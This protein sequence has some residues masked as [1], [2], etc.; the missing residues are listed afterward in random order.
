MKLDPGTPLEW[1]VA[2][3]IDE[4]AVVP[5]QPVAAFGR[6]VPQKIFGCVTFLQIR[7]TVSALAWAV[8]HHHLHNSQLWRFTHCRKAAGATELLEGLLEVHPDRELYMGIFYRG[9]TAEAPSSSVIDMTKASL[10]ELDQDNLMFFKHEQHWPLGSQSGVDIVDSS[11]N[12]E[13]ATQPSGALMGACCE[14]A[15]GPPVKSNTCRELPLLAKQAP[16]Q[17]MADSLETEETTKRLR[18]AHSNMFW[19]HTWLPPNPGTKRFGI[20]RV[21]AKNLWT[22]FYELKQGQLHH[23]GFARPPKSKSKRWGGAVTEHNCWQTVLSWIWE[24][25]SHNVGSGPPP[26]IGM[27][28][29]HCENCV[30]SACPDFV[31]LSMVAADVPDT[32]G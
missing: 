4:W 28:M 12:E 17:Q 5:W 25:H 2:T 20:Y 6:H 3:D 18:S 11:G 10:A 26:H 32:S 14:A 31:A 23:S 24:Q 21:E 29:R 15:V 1:V 30:G 7:P 27:A 16:V 9:K 13:A 22:A 19:M 8:A